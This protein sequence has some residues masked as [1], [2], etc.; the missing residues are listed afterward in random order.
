[1][2]NLT[3]Y[4]LF[5]GCMKTIGASA[6]GRLLSEYGNEKNIYKLSEKQIMNL[7]ILTP[8]QKKEFCMFKKKFDID[9]SLEKMIKSGIKFVTMDMEE[10]PG[11]LKNI[12]N[13]PYRLFYYGEL[14][15]DDIPSVAVIGARKC[16]PYGEEMAA[17]FSKKLA[18]SGIQIVSGLASGI[19]GRAQWEALEAGGKS[20]GIL[21]CGVDICY[22]NE[23]KTLYNKLKNNGGIIS[24]FAPGTAPLA[25]N[26]PVRNRIISGLSDIV[27]VVEAKEKS[28]TVITVNMALEQG[29]DV[30]AVPGR[31]IDALSYGCNKLISEGAGIAYNVDCILENIN[32]NRS[33]EK[34]ESKDVLNGPL[35]ENMAEFDNPIWNIVIDT[36]YNKTQTVDDIFSALVQKNINI[37][38][39][40]LK[41]EM[42]QMELEGIICERGGMYS[43]C[44]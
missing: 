38:I 41:I 2:D 24:E 12:P 22:P 35:N 39:E 31:C 9:K 15:R 34:C 16:S 30:F 20:Y 42:M 33:E 28:G 19:D 3:K 13:K 10:Y 26:F 43:K 8:N 25:T 17:L 23:N 40:D 37:N 14:P 21:G 11:R 32:I 6:M 36:I 29:K 1:M 5:F 18:L 4:K 44:L 7:K 27:L